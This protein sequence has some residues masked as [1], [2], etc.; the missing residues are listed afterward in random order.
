MGLSDKLDQYF[1]EPL[2]IYERSLEIKNHY[3]KYKDIFEGDE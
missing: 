3:E 2:K 1:L